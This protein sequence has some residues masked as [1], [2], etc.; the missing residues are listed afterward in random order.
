MLR[1]ARAI[2]C[3]NNADTNESP[4][5]KKRQISLQNPLVLSGDNAVWAAMTVSLR[6]LETPRSGRLRGN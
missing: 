6:L 1:V 5:H 4:F 3:S 2:P